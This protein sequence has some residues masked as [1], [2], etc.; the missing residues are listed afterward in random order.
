M[1]LVPFG[2]TVRPVDKVLW[3]AIG[4]GDEAL[5]RTLLEDQGASLVTRNLENQT[6]LHLAVLNGH[7]AIARLL[8]ERGADIEA[9]GDDGEKPLYIAA[10]TGNFAIARV[11][12]QFNASAESFNVRKQLSALHRAVEQGHEEIVNLLLRHGADVDLQNSN[13]ETALFDAVVKGNSKLATLLLRNGA[14]KDIQ[15]KDGRSILTIA[16]GDNTMM[17]LLQKSYLLRGP[18]INHEKEPEEFRFSQ[19]PTPPTVENKQEHQVDATQGFEMTIIDF[20]IGKHEQRVVNTTSVWD[21]LYGRGPDIIMNR[22]RDSTEDDNE[23]TFRWYHFPANNMAWVEA[24]VSRL[25]AEQKSGAA[26][27]TDEFKSNLGLTNSAGQQ[28]QTATAHSSFM[29]PLCRSVKSRPETSFGTGEGDHVML[30]M[31]YLH[32]ED[33]YDYGKMSRVISQVKR[34]TEQDRGGEMSDDQPVYTRMSR[35]H[36]SLE[37]LHKYRIDYELDQDPEYILINRWVP[38]YEQ[39]FLWA[40]SRETREKRG[41]QRILA[42]Q[43]G[44]VGGEFEHVISQAHHS[45]T[46]EAHRVRDSREEPKS[47]KSRLSPWIIWFAGGPWPGRPDR[48]EDRRPPVPREITIPTSEILVTPGT[49]TKTT[50]QPPGIQ[51]T[52]S[53]STDRIDTAAHEQISGSIKSIKLKNG[54][55]RSIAQGDEGGNENE[56]R[57]GQ[58]RLAS[59]SRAQ[60]MQTEEAVPEKTD[61][62]REDSKTR[63]AHAPLMT[64]DHLN[65][66]LIRGYLLPLSGKP[67]F[68]QPRR[69]LDQYF[70][71]HLKN[72]TMRDSDQVVYRHMLKRNMPPKIFMV[73]QLWLWILNGDTIITCCPQRWR[74]WSE[75]GPEKSA[76]QQRRLVTMS[77]DPL[78]VH[79]MVLKFLKNPA[80]E[81]IT[82]IYDLAGVI[83]D[84]T[85]SVFDPF[86]IS[87]EFQFLDFFERSIGSVSNNEAYCFQRFTE[88]LGQSASQDSDSDPRF[89]ITR[90][91]NLLV[92]IK[93][94]RDE[95]SIL[96]MVLS[97]QAST[98]A[99]LSRICS[100]ARSE[101]TPAAA[102]QPGDPPV[103]IPNRVLDSHMWRIARMDQL[104]E[105]TYQSLNNLIDLKQKQA[106]I[107]E[108]LSARKQAENTLRQAENTSRQAEHAASQAESTAKLLAAGAEQAAETARQGKTILV[109][110]VIT[111]IFLPLSFMAAFFAIA[112]E[113]FPFNDN[114]KLDLGYVLK[115]MLSVSGAVAIPFILIAFNQDRIVRWMSVFGRVFFQHSRDNG[116]LSWER[117]RS[118]NKLDAPSTAILHNAIGGV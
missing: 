35:R 76:T 1:S 103:V 55:E 10:A 13:G 64:I 59:G 52:F 65:E 57:D 96:Q 36:L 2:D 83:T 48:D 77:D 72:T 32:F 50:Y 40:S 5:V 47:G 31:P 22:N 38:E 4:D 113:S 49:L 54:S 41:K 110:T 90:E 24:L 87:D 60:T 106:S 81:P 53:T 115:Y 117:K 73:D 20:V 58:P 28:Y 78:N 61:I 95:L 27:L 23:K 8:L 62:P 94:I 99:D 112:I 69:T 107:S 18:S 70:Y 63:K 37:V 16:A 11:L 33:Y 25:S 98:M 14:N 92:E 51:G 79:Q 100:R 101:L 46:G 82:S 15:S 93:D 86:R 39:D 12:L 111:I 84:C 71:T 109:F 45:V 26:M 80:R 3:R 44:K 56:R 89:N 97:H 75:V 68:L 114:G 21:V 88:S 29:R 118:S 42:I 34:L 74:S 19:I 67:P 7:E 105:K 116:G 6:A 17:E 104:A 66:S 85:A 43:D 91:T 30:F 102:L 9:A 108:A